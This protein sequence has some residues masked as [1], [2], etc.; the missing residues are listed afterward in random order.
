MISGVANLFQRQRTP[1]YVAVEGGH[2]QTVGV[3]LDY[4][5]SLD[6]RVSPHRPQC[7]CDVVGVLCAKTESFELC[8]KK[9]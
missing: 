3:L 9:R 4:M 6:K 8:G 7:T 5:H 1:L 2:V